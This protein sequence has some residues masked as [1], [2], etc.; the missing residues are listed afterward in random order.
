MLVA[1]LRPKIARLQADYAG[2]PL[3]VSLWDGTQHHFGAGAPT[4]TLRFGTPTALLRSLL[5]GSLGFGESYASGDVTVDGDLDDV[6]AAFMPLY[7]TMPSAGPLQ[8]WLKKSLLLGARTLPQE[9]ADIEHHYGISDDFYRC[10]LDDELQ[11]SCAYFRTPADTLE[12]AQ[13]QKICHTVAKLRLE[14]GQRLLDVGCGWGH[15]MFHA[16]ERYGV[17]CV[18]ITLCE[19]QATYIREQARARRLPVSVRVT[20]YLELDTTVK[21][22]RLVSVGMMCHIGERRIDEFYDRIRALLAPQAICLLHA[23]VKMREQSG[24][25][26]FVSRHVFP[27]Y[28]F[29]SVEGMTRRAVDRG[30]EILDVENLR[31]HYHLTAQHWRRRFRDN[32]T[33]IRA[34]FGFDERF[35]R[36]WEFYLASV[37]AAF[38]TGRNSLIQMVMS[39]GINDAYPLTR[40]HLYGLAAP[41][42]EPLSRR[43]P[44]QVV[45]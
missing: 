36:T 11:Y 39:N 17:E 25:D 3:R 40:E 31:R 28:W 14:R 5:Q 8:G 19:N 13:Q 6:L 4:F 2:P 37:A 1:L 18:G 26:P 29:N 7:L 43:A 35:M 45:G 38:R 22:D 44:A 9:R 30:L 24:S 12:Q 15:L 10:Y 34:R 33:R 20:S 32:W 41:A 27:G 21:W 16:A 23:I 42:I